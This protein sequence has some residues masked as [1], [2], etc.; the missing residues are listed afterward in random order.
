MLWWSLAVLAM[1]DYWSGTAVVTPDSV[2][3]SE[4]NVMD[5]WNQGIAV[6]DR[7]SRK[8]L[9]YAYPGAN[10]MSFTPDASGRHLLVGRGGPGDTPAGL[11]PGTGAP[12]TP[13][14]PSYELVRVD[15]RPPVAAA[16][17]PSPPALPRGAAESR[18]PA[19]GGLGRRT[20]T[21]R[22][23][24]VAAGPDGGSGR[25]RVSPPGRPRGPGPGRRSAAGSP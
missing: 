1:D 17:T 22:A 9:G 5:H 3:V 10:F 24:L 15:L 18:S 21:V 4:H 14:G 2:I 6:Y 20:R 12:P 16:P 25:G 7:A 13:A 8:P 11:W 19:A 23:R